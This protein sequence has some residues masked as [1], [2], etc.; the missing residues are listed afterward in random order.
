MAA[1]RY[2]GESTAEMREC[3]RCGSKTT[4]EVCRKCRLLESLAAV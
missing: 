4:R 3:E 1:D 2:R